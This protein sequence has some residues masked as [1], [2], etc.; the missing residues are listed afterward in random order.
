MVERIA[1]DTTLT[2][3]LAD[4]LADLNAYPTP[5]GTR[6]WETPEHEALMARKHDLL[7]RCE[8]AD[9]VRLGTTEPP[10]HNDGTISRA[11]ARLDGLECTDG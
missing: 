4:W 8:A 7:R 2:R 9:E 6:W 3:D 5:L 1:P 10:T 11:Y